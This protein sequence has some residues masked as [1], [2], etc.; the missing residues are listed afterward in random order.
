MNINCNIAQNCEHIAQRTEK[1]ERIYII[2]L[3]FKNMYEC[4]LK[5]QN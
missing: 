2:H 3:S 1:P 4:P 5:L